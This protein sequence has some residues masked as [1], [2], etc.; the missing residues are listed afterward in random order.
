MVMALLGV[1]IGNTGGGILDFLI[2]G[3]LQGFSIKWYL[4]PIVGT[5]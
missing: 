3:I 5:V 1:T 2:F 4:V